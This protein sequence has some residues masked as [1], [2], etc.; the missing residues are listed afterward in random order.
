MATRGAE[1]A[2]VPCVIARVLIKNVYAV[3]AGF[4]CVPRCTWVFL[5]LSPAEFRAKISPSTQKIDNLIRTV[6]WGPTE[7]GDD[8]YTTAS[9]LGVTENGK[10]NI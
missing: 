10:W 7:I 5:A 4:V 6:A 8:C 2:H 3:S 9:S 1:H